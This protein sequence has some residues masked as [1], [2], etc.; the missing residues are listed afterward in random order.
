M[1]YSSLAMAQQAQEKAMAAAQR[2]IVQGFA[3]KIELS[4]GGAYQV[5]SADSVNLTL[6]IWEP[7]IGRLQVCW[8]IP[9]A[10]S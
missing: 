9:R 10:D 2:L 4:P 1:A 3:P 5:K 6:T 8:T 7:E